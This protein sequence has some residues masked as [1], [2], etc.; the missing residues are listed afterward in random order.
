MCPQP[1]GLIPYFRGLVPWSLTC[2]Y[3]PS[4]SYRSRSYWF[5]AAA[6]LLLCNALDAAFTGCAIASGCAT[7]ANPLMEELLRAGP[8][9]F[10]LGKHLLV[11]LGVLLL[12]RLRTVRFA[13]V[14]LYAMLPV[15]AC[16]IGYHVTMAATLMAE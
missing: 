14:G 9:A 3:I 6:L 16:I 1:R 11:S 5:F 8:L 4:M 13:R 2:T 7:E 15:Y 10:A 12:W